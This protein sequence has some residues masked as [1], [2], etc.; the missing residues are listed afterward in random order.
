[1]SPAFFA[2]LQAALNNIDLDLRIVEELFAD[3]APRDLEDGTVALH[4]GTLEVIR[5]MV[6]QAAD[7]L[8]DQIAKINKKKSKGGE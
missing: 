4:P 1:M 6:H 3:I 8:E 7:R 2:D 5:G